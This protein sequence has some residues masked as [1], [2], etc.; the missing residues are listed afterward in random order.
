MV[1]RIYLFPKAAQDPIVQMSLDLIAIT[2]GV[3]TIDFNQ[4]WLDS[5][6]ILQTPRIWLMKLIE[7]KLGRAGG[8]PCF[9]SRRFGIKIAK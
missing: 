5:Q 7:Y 1:Y 3:R 6:T 2:G 4:F 9:M 8:I